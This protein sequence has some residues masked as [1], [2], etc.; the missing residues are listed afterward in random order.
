MDELFKPMLFT[1]LTSSAGFAS[2][3]LTPIPPVQVFGVF[4][5]F[6]IMLAWLLTIFFIPAYVIMLSEKGLA[7]LGVPKEVKKRNSVSLLSRCL[8]GLSGSTYR[9]SKL[10]ISLTLVTLVIAGCGISRIRINDN[11]VKWFKKNHAIREADT[12]LNRHFGGTYE[13]Y[14]I[15]E[16][17]EK[18]ITL[19]MAAKWIKDEIQKISDDLSRPLVIPEALDSIDKQTKEDMT[20]DQLIEALTESWE[21]KQD[22]ADDDG[23]DA[24]SEILDILGRLENRGQVFKRP[25]VLRYVATLQEHLLTSGMVGK[26]N[27]ITDVVKKVYQELFE[28]NADYYRVPD[29]VPAVAQCLI[30]FQNS[31]KPNDLFH[32]VTPD[33]HKANIWIQLKTGD[34]KDMEAVVA[35]VDQFMSSTPPPVELTHKWAGLTYLNIVWQDKMVSGML[36]SFLGSFVVVFVMMA[37]LFR[38]P[39]WGLIAMVPLSVTIALIYGIIGLAGK[40]YD[41]PVAVLSSLT[42]GLAID[43]AIHFLERSRMTFT[44]RGTWGTAI[45]EMFEEPGRAIARNVIVIAVG[46]TPLLAA[47]L[48][49]YITVGVFLASIMAISGMGTLL[50][51]PSLI[52]I[53]QYRLFRKLR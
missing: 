30:S 2:L 34:N 44:K 21:E 16:S 45:K 6:G 49:P 48:V 7:G 25:D 4:V 51:L 36:R 53:L 38:S 26:S 11:P 13:A 9:H 31:H 33:Y 40:D 46:F 18:D 28:G 20:V 41:M 39:L 19:D 1:S 3:A 43:F 22:L 37:F 52:T 17:A 47:P 32:L 27:T 15:L 5:A 10:I 8:H 12:V 50:I 24:W 35:S 23:Y 29:S 42:L 14:L